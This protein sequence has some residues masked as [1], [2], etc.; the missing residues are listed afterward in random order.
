MNTKAKLVIVILAT[1]AALAA[2]L[3]FVLAR[4][5]VTWEQFLIGLGMLLAPGA[6]VVPLLLPGLVRRR[7]GEDSD[8][9]ASGVN[10][11]L[12]FCWIGSALAT[13]GVVS[14]GC[15]LAR[16]TRAELAEEAY[17]KESQ[18][19]VEQYAI[20]RDIRRCFADVDRRARVD[21]GAP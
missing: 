2:G 7:R 8:P 3:V 6:S 18:R 19:C 5:G 15:A 17:R 21:A 4:Q 16:A 12:A 20:E 1:N 11:I 13:V 9:P 10:A 14:S